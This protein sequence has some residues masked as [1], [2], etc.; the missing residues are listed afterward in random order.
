MG[1]GA[2]TAHVEVHDIDGDGVSIFTE[3]IVDELAEL[4]RPPLAQ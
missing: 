3:P 1:W 4:S 2:V